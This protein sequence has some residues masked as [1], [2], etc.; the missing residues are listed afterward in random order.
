M[1]TTDEVTLPI[2][3]P[4]VASSSSTAPPTLSKHTARRVVSSGGKGVTG[5]KTDG[6]EIPKAI[7][8]VPAASVK[9]SE[10]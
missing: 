8:D 5:K 4:S 3:I 1:V 7:H 9:A 10:K 2:G 6:M